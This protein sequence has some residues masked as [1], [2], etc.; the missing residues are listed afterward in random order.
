MW[1]GELGLEYSP[2]PLRLDLNKLT[3]IADTKTGPVPMLQMGSGENWLWCHLIA[4]L[5]LHKWFVDKGRPVPRFLILDQPTQVY[6]PI[7]RDAGG[8]LDGLK[9]TARDGV[10]RI[11]RWLKARVDELKGQFQV[12]VTDHAEV[13]EPWFAEAV[14]ERWRGGK[15]LVPKAW[16]NGVD[17]S[18]PGTAAPEKPP[19]SSEVSET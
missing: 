10:V 6:Y 9:D 4:H 8:S 13:K 14:V 12:I 16:A 7:D 11:F 3:V 17:T 15:A 19:G 2:F 18:P 1:S 5:A